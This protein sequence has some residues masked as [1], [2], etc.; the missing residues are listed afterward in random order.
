MRLRRMGPLAVLFLYA[1]PGWCQEKGLTLEEAL[2]LAREQG[3]DVVLARGRIE[4]ARA[5]R[6]QAGRRFQENPVLEVEGGPR[7]AEDDSLDFEASLSQGLRAGRWRSARVAG[8]QA[9]LD[10]AEA[11]LAEARRRLLREVRIVFVRSL[12][13]RDRVELLARNRRAANELLAATGR[14]YEAGEATALELNRARTVAA[15]ARAEQSAA[16]AEEAL[17]GAGLKALLGLPTGES[18]EIRGSLAPS[19]PPGL[20][21]L[22]ANLDRRPDLEALAAEIREA[23]AEVLLGEALARPEWGLRGG[24]AREEDAEIVTAGF[25]VSLPVHNRGQ[26]TLAA[27]QAR[28]AAL[29]EALEAARRAADAEV[30]GSHAALNRRLAAV[31]ELE[32]TALPSLDDNESLAV[33]SFE[34][35]EIDLGELLLIRREILETRL[36]YLDRLLEASLTRLDLEAAAGAQP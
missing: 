8:A 25:V 27:G 30:R 9:G 16:E 13:E 23:E 14:R 15:G 4:E 29:R 32:E 21:D 22:L 34:A 26:E 24:V 5:R 7:F 1:F 2:A 20:D 36:T 6:A 18:L 17:A 3:A 33:K 28:A 35:G 10:R 11:E 12:A 31:R 19:A